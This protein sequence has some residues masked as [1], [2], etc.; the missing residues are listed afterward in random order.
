MKLIWYLSSF[1]TVFL[2]LLSNPKSNS[3]SNL[4]MQNSLFSYTKSSQKNIQVL[5]VMSGGV[6]LL[7][8]VILTNNISK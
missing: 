3:F 4:G 6:F 8:T 7:I 1:L 2:I 5:T